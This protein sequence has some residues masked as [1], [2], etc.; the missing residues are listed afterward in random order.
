MNILELKQDM[1]S[2]HNKDI[3]WCYYNHS[4]VPTTA[5]HEEP[6][7]SPI[8]DGSIWHIDGQKPLFVRYTTDWDCGFDTGWWYVIKDA[9]FDIESLS[10]SSRKHIRSALRKVRVERINPSEHFSELFECYKQAC[11]KYKLAD[12]LF[13][14]ESFQKYYINAEA[15]KIAFWAGFSMQDNKL[16]GYMTVKQNQCWSEICAA[17]FD[18]RFLNL[19]ISDALYASVLDYYLNKQGNKYISSGSRSI[20]HLTNTQEYKEQHFN[21]RKCYC[22]LNI[23][24]RPDVKKIV[25]ILYPLRYIINL[26]GRFSGVFHQISGVL[27]MES[28]VR[29]NTRACV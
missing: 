22:R 20:N 14:F 21:Y 27:T 16:V 6:D 10:K 9:P 25:K 1:R 13:S 11:Q 24:Y 17:K 23:V 2:L 19:Q 18:P 7:L 4:V 8:E 5:P 28:I 3:G 26:L 15:E 12:N 29:K